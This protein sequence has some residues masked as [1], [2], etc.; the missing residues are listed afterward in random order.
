EE[1]KDSSVVV[2]DEKNEPPARLFKVDVH[3]KKMS[4]LT[5]NP[6]RIETMAV[7]PN[8]RYAVALHCRS[9]R[10]AFDNRIKPVAYLHDLE[11]GTRRRIFED[12]RLNIKEFRWTHDGKGFY[13]INEHSSRPQFC[14]G[15]L[16]ELYYFDVTAGVASRLDLGWE[17]GL[18]L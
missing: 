1:R 10:Y 12:P 8:G 11:A 15:G 14:V 18:A 16:I 7:S 6:D 13:A 5:D 17:S 2:E 3:S 9:L 4:R